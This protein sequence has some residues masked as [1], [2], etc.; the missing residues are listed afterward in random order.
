MNVRHGQRGPY[1]AGQMRD[2]DDLLGRIVGE[3]SAQHFL[4]GVN[5]RRDTHLAVLGQ[6]PEVIR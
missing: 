6:F 4:G 5:P 1:D 3:D 2:V